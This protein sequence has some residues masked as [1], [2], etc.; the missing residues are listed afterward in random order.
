[1]IASEADHEDLP[2]QRLVCKAWSR[3]TARRFATMFQQTAF[4][5]TK[6]GMV[7]M[8]ATS[9]HSQFG[10]EIQTLLIIIDDKRK[11]AA[12]IHDTYRMALIA[13]AGRGQQVRLG[14]R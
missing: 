2:E 14:V 5:F 10:P 1:M 8:L 3:A 6:H 7:E 4:P 13:L 12:I 11:H 9:Q